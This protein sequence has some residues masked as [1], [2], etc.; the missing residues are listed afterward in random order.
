[1]GDLVQLREVRGIPGARE[2]LERIRAMREGLEP[3]PEHTIRQMTERWPEHHWTGEQI[4]GLEIVMRIHPP[5]YVLTVVEDVCAEAG[6]HPPSVN[7]LHAR[8]TNFGYPRGRLMPNGVRWRA[9]G[10]PADPVGTIRW[11]EVER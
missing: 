6:D 9:V 2:E 1:M 4:D 8:I 11:Q 7:A 3:V 5:E 10:D